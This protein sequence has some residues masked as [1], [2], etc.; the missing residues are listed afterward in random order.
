MRYVGPLYSF[1]NQYSY[2]LSW[3]LRHYLEGRIPEEGFIH[4]LIK[5]EIKETI[6]LLRRESNV[7]FLGGKK[8]EELPGYI[9]DLDVCLM[10]YR[11]TAY[12]KYIFPLKL[13]EYL[14][15]GKPIVATPLEN[16]EEFKDVLYFADMKKDWIENIQRC[17]EDQNTEL[18]QKRISVARENS[19]DIR[20]KDIISVFQEKL[21]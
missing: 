18:E 8:H 1:V 10:C 2:C 7:Y 17:L 19:W 4:N 5:D 15:C 20:A 11:R 13:N 16:F 6:K 14:A 21:D 12:T 9:K 3:N